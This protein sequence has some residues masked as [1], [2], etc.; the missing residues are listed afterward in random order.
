MGLAAHSPIQ[1]VAQDELFDAADREGLL[2][3]T[4]HAL[5]PWPTMS[6]TN[7][8]PV[9]GIAQEELFDAA[10]RENLLPAPTFDAPV[11]W[12]TMSL[13]IPSPVQS[14]AQEELFDAADREN[15]LPAPPFDARV[16]WPTMSPTIPS[17]VQ[18]VAQEEV[19]DA[20]T[21]RPSSPQPN[22]AS[23][24]YF[25]RM[26][27]QGAAAQTA[28]EQ[29]FPAAS[30][31]FDAS[32]AV[33]KDFSYGT[34]AA[35]ELMRSRLSRWGLLPDAAQRVK[36]YDIGGERYTA[37][38]GPGGPMMFSSSICGLP[39]SAIRLMFRSPCPRIF[40]IARSWPRK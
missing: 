25:G 32:L 20:A 34:Q 8:S 36:T 6:P 1:S 16:P 10:D 26:M 31:S 14:V 23:E 11:P 19:F 9:Q 21:W 17:P 39:L 37:V 38:L 3:A 15:L 30:D 4:T 29:T 12:P 40:P 33:P 7:A 24:D 27:N 2:L 22:S 13:T 28:L 35:P 5:V 18:S